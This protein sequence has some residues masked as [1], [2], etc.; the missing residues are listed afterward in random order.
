[1][2]MDLITGLS[3]S[4]VC[5]ELWVIVDR[6]SKMAHFIPLLAGS[7]TAADLTRIPA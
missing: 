1:M 4:G 5:D 6:F 3:V 7:K 2:S